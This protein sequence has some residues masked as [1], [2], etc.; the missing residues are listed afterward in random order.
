MDFLKNP[1]IY[2]EDGLE[3]NYFK[4]PMDCYIITFFYADGEYYNVLFDRS[5]LPKCSD[6]ELFTHIIMVAIELIQNN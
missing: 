2:E 1:P 4:P 6:S 5:D 3:I